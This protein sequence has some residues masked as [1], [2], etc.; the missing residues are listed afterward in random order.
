MASPG[1]AQPS[2]YV[3]LHGTTQ[4]FR[5]VYTGETIS[6]RQYDKR[7]RLGPRGYSSYEALA[8]Q[9]AHAGYAGLA[10]T[11]E[12]IDRAI[13]RVLH[14]G[15]SPTRAARAEH[16]SPETLR[17]FDRERGILRYNRRT[18]R[19]EVHAA[20]HVSFFDAT[21]RLHQDIPFDHL[22]I[23]TMSAYGAAV[24]TAKAGRPAALQSFADVRVQDIFGT[25]YTLLANINAYLRAEQLHGDLDTLDFFQSGDV[26]VLPPSATAAA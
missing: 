7:F 13:Q 9:R 6:R 11:K 24:K 23:Q 5:N 16:L 15:V 2:D 1:P 10:R 22:A 3:P 8:R 17:R 18:R 4:R 19:G 14:T 25:E 21:S 12:R 26:L 20:G